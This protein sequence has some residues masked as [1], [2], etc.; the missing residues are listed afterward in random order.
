[1]KFWV[2]LPIALILGCSDQLFQSN[3]SVANPNPA[4]QT[5]PTLLAKASYLSPLE[6]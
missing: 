6:Q 5:S 3:P 4:L 2:F 1:M